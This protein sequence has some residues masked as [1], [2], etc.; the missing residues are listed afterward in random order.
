MPVPHP[1]LALSPSAMLSR[2]LG[3]SASLLSI[4]RYSGAAR[5]S[6]AA[7]ACASH[8]RVPT[9]AEATASTRWLKSTCSAGASSRLAPKLHPSSDWKGDSRSRATSL[10]EKRRKTAAKEMHAARGR[11]AILSA[12]MTGKSARLH[13]QMKKESCAY[14]SGLSHRAASSSSGLVRACRQQA[15]G[16]RQHG[17]RQSVQAAAV[18]ARSMGREHGQSTHTHAYARGLTRLIVEWV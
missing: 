2:T 18:Q 10:R 17:T 14:G 1:V 16:S 4:L 13:A 7:T 3:P 5:P 6:P 15:A 9:D 12:T 8:E 11:E